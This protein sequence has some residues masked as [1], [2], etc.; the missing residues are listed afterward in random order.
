M[1][2]DGTHQLLVY[3]DDVN[4]LGDNIDTIKRNTHTLID[5]S[6]EFGLEVN[7]EKTKCTRVG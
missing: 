6:K 7:I 1:K 5:V 4:L 3:A 2:L